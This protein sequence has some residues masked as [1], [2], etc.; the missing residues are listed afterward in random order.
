M[1]QICNPYLLSCEYIP[2]GEPHVFEGRLYLYGSHDRFDS[3][4]FCLNDYVCWSAPADDLKEWRYEG[5]IFRKDQDP[6]NQN[7][8][9]NAPPQ[10]L[11]YG[12]PP[13]KPSDLNPR[14][15]HAMDTEGRFRSIRL[16]LSAFR[17]PAP[18]PPGVSLTTKPKQSNRAAASV[19]SD[20]QC[21]F[22]FEEEA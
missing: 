16:R 15:V 11:V 21:G 22:G 9:D 13:K 18:S 14:G 20:I 7:I 5:V 6:V 19:A 17:Q 12:I 1:K 4:G 2:D 3:S 10:P 8:P